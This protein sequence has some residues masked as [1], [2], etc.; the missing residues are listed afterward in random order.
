M[1][2]QPAPAPDNQSADIPQPETLKPR[3]ENS[4]ADSNQPN[5][6]PA[7]KSEKDIK[8]IRKHT[9]RPSH[10]ATFI[11][12]GIVV[13]ILAFN[14]IGIDIVLRREAKS[15]KQ[16]NLGA[17]S[18]SSSTLSKLGVNN[19]QAGNGVVL[20]IEPDTQLKG[21]LTV[22]GNASLGGQ[23][24]LN[25][26]LN[27]SN[28][29]FTQLQAGNTSLSQ[30][31]VNGDGTV[32][33]FNLRKDLVV[34][35]ITRLQGAVT[36]ISSMDVNGNLTVGGVLSVGSFSAKSLT[37]T[38]TLTVD[39]HVITGGARPN[40]GGAG[41]LGSNGTVSLSGDD[42]AGVININIGTGAVAGT[43]VNVA[44]AQ[45]YGAT[46]H[47]V[48]TPVGVGASFYITNLTIGGFS[49]NVASGLPPGGYSIE[50]IVEQ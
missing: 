31:N 20:T 26:Q 5:A 12:I 47:V 39:G 23:L 13:I 35:G 37:S 44:F 17:V 11:G 15:N 9:Y 29:T 24:L 8:K 32:T 33:N 22:A 16:S 48:I 7:P 43:L 46:P 4:S 6:A 18:I 38:S 30:I 49:V 14:A 41:A 19:Q 2:S 27:G 42:S 28:A 36:V 3:S 34:A 25:G 50:Y 21:K 10:K 1:D 45:Q 40:V